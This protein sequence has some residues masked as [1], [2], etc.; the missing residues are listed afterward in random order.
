MPL[1][2]APGFLGG[3][4]VEALDR[5]QFVQIDI[6]DFLDRAETFEAS[7]CARSRRRRGRS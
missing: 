3:L 4:G 6:G 7:N 5:G 1:A 2:R